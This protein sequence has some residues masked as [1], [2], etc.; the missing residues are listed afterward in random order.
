MYKGITYLLTWLMLS[1][2]K[3]NCL[4]KVLGAK[5]QCFGV[6]NI[7]LYAENVFCKIISIYHIK[8]NQ[9][10]CFEKCP[11]RPHTF[12]FSMRYFPMISENFLRISSKFGERIQIQM[13]T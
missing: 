3:D 4:E 13:R 11:F 6:G 7:N 12:L 8:S 2:L 10:C 1:D 5:P 9:L